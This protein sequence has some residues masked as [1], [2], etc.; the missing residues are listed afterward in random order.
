MATISDHIA[1]GTADDGVGQPLTAADGTPLKKKLAQANRRARLRAT[2]LVAPLLLFVLITFVV[3]IGQ[4]LVQ[5]F[6]EPTFSQVL[7]RTTAALQSWDGRDLPDESVYA[8]FAEDLKDARAN[9]T[10]GQVATR[11]NYAHAGSRS[12]FT[13]TARKAERFE[14]PFKEALIAADEDWGDRELWSAMKWA[15]QGYTS[16]FYLAAVDRTRDVDGNIV[17]VEEYRQIYVKILLR[18]LYLAGLITGLC[19]LLGYPVA[20]L[21]ASLPT[22]TSNL[23]MILVLLPFWT[24]LLVRTTAWIALLQSQGV[25]ND[26][27]VALRFIDDDSR[28]QMIYNQTGTIIAMTHILLPFA[29]LPLFSVMKTIPPSYMRAARSLGATPWTAFWR[30]YVPQTVPGIA[31]GV[32]LV[33]ILAVGYYITPALVGGQD[34]QLISNFIALHMQKTLNWSM[35]AA[36]GGILL[37]TILVLY[38]LF[39]KM[40]GIDRL[41]LG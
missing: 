31:A 5:S 32:L 14:A 39:N 25:V 26:I 21:L 24:S 8:A 7:P 13:S 4:M 29:I 15:S 40:V 11:V 28:L 6:Y 41:K 33:F 30:V 20:Y 1:A 22:R 27:L 18:T 38:W 23:L 36:L 2:L 19:L 16:E 12:A 3:P 34:G 35:A 37:A 17:M 9:R 10:I